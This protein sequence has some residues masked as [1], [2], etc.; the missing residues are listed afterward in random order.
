LGITAPASLEVASFTTSPGTITAGFSKFTATVKITDTCGQPVQGAS[1][2]VTAVP[3]QQVTTEQGVTGPSGTVTLE[4]SRLS[5]FPA[6]RHQELMV[7]FV[8]AEQGSG[9]AAGGISARRLV[10]VPVYL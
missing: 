10:S 7:F 9:D 5:G 3:Y 8:R 2:Y 6:D 4:F 1:V